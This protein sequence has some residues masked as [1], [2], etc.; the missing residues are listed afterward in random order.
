MAISLVH[1]G[2]SAYQFRLPVVA[3]WNEMIIDLNDR[4]N[5]AIATGSNTLSE[6]RHPTR[7]SDATDRVAFSRLDS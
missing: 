3:P 4:A 7:E 2:R 6:D 5:L 1:F